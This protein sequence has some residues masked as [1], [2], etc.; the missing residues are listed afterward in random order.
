MT[1]NIPDWVRDHADGW[2]VDPDGYMRVKKT[3]VTSM[4]VSLNKKEAEVEKLR[5]LVPEV[6]VERA[7]ELPNH[8]WRVQCVV[9]RPIDV[10]PRQ[11]GVYLGVAL[12]DSEL[13]MLREQGYRVTCQEPAD[14]VPGMVKG[15]VRCGQCSEVYHPPSIGNRI[16]PHCGNYGVD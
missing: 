4:L 12:D 8:V 16:C 13:D 11:R 7:G 6:R 14:I 5:A 2:P 1:D 15:D 9:K 3:T 10:G